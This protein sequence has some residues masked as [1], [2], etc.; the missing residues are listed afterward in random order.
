MTTFCRPGRQPAEAQAEDEDQQVGEREG[1]DRER[2]QRD[3]TDP[4]ARQPPPRQHR[5]RP[6]A[7]A[8][9]ERDQ[10]C[11]G[12][13][14]DRGRE[15]LA[16]LARDRLLRPHRGAEVA[17]QP[18]ARLARVALQQ[19]AVETELAADLLDLARRHL[20]PEAR[21]GDGRRGVTGRRRQQQERH[22]QRG[23]QHR[24]GLAETSR[25]EQSESGHDGRLPYGLTVTPASGRS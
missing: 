2:Q 11:H 15:P 22:E 18:A 24:G 23:Q 12:G 4:G 9:D 19:R 10:S 20:D 17:A 5:E 7:D 6:A 3:G 21:L 13:Q 1:G 14:L 8:A 25:N 16:D